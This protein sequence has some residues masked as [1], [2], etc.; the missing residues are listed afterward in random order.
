MSGV[1]AAT[2]SMALTADCNF[3]PDIDPDTSITKWM[4]GSVPLAACACKG[5]SP[6]TASAKETIPVILIAAFLN[7]PSPNRVPKMGCSTRGG[8]RR[9]LVNISIEGAS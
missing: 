7:M 6:I 4:A 9:E 3:S 1:S 2:A 5:H 8:G